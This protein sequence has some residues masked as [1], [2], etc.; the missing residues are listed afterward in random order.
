MDDGAGG[1]ATFLGVERSIC[2]RRWRLRSGDV[3]EGQVIAERLALPEIVGRLLAQR[4][5]DY[6]H[7]PGFLAPRLRDQL[8]APSPL[9]DMDAAVERLVRPIPERE[10][11]A[12]F[13]ASNAST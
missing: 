3:Q 13:R 4:G 12:L 6:N 7:A 8:P 2:G 5:I 10:S 11:I 1:A 9:R